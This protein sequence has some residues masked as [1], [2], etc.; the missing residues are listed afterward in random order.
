MQRPLLFMHIPKTGGATLNSILVRLY[1]DVRQG[2]PNSIQAHETLVKEDPTELA[3]I[4]CFHGHFAFGLHQFLGRESVYITLFRDPVERLVSE[5]RYYCRL[6]PDFR[7]KTGSL[8]NWLDSSW[9]AFSHNVATR[10][11]AGRHGAISQDDP[12]VLELAKTNLEMVQLVGLTER[13]DESLLLFARH[14]GWP[15]PLYLSFNRAQTR[16]TI[17]HHLRQKIERLNQ[18]DLALYAMAQERFEHLLL[19]SPPGAWDLKLFRAL[20]FAY[21]YRLPRLLWSWVSRFCD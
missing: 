2:F 9:S 16:P 10:I 12:A 17:D 21:R 6:N 11:L 14:L 7:Q 5:Y 3:K 8:E 13:F 20:N 15:K 18:F 1:P 4:E 19:S